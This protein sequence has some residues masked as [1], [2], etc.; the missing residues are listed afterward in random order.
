MRAANRIQRDRKK[1]LTEGVSTYASQEIDHRVT[2]ASRVLPVQAT[3][4]GNFF[5]PSVF[6]VS[7]AT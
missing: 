6:G 7:R 2:D 5:N 1:G 3:A 4:R